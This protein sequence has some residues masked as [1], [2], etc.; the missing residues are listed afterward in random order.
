MITI[1]KSQR[2]EGTHVKYNPEIGKRRTFPPKML[3]IGTEDENP[4]M[5]ERRFRQAFLDRKTMVES[6]Y[7][8]S[9]E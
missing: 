9:Q 2:G 1:S 5:N 3:E 7:K 8:E 4:E 6:L